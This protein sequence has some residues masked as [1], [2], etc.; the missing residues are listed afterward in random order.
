[1]PAFY[2][3]DPVCDIL[4]FGDSAIRNRDKQYR[5]GPIDF[6]PGIWSND[7]RFLKFKDWLSVDLT[8]R[9][10]AMVD[11]HG[12][13]FGN[14]VRSNWYGLRYVGG[15]PSTPATYPLVDNEYL[16][17][18]KGLSNRIVKP[19]HENVIR[20]ITRLFF[21]DLVPQPM[22][23]RVN[24][25][26][27]MPHYT[28][29]MNEKIELATYALTSGKVAAELIMKGD[30]TTAWK[31]YYIGGAYH[32]VYRR[33]SSDAVT[34]ENGVFT[35][36]ERPVAD[37]EYALSGGRK[38]TFAPTNRYFKGDEFQMVPN[39]FR[40]RNRTAMGGPLGLNAN[41]M[42]IAQ[43][44][45]S[46]I[47]DRYAF[48]YH[49]TTRD[50]QQQ[51]MRRFVMNVAADVSNHD[52]FFPSWLIQDI[53]AD[54]L[55]KM[56]F[57]E[58][59]VELY[60]L[61]MKLPNY[62]TDVGPGEG[63]VLLGDWRNPSNKGGLPSGN[64]FTDI[65]GTMLMTWCYF[66][67]QVEHTYPEVIP[68]LQTVQSACVVMD[69]YLRGKMPICLKDKSDDA[70]LGWQERHLI[71]RAEKLLSMMKDDSNAAKISPYMIISYEHGGAFLG[72]ILL[73]PESMDPSK[74]IL[75][76][77]INSLAVNAF[78]PEYGVQGDLKKPEDRAKTKRPY[79]GL[80]WETLSQNY[81]SS[82][83]YGDVMDRIEFWWSRAFDFS[84]RQYRE[85][86]LIRDKEALLAAL[87]QRSLAL[88]DLSLIEI[89]VLSDPSKLDWKYDPSQVSPSIVKLMFN[90]LE[91]EQVVPYFESVVPR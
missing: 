41:L 63:N 74:L 21:S 28:R 42:P 12:R 16:R 43:S 1:M 85:E 68:Q 9:F 80:A 32:T 26:S 84:Y 36:K 10:P 56:G 49:H 88:P 78:S 91:L 69:G 13:V 5:E 25:S 7:Y 75:I 6:H 20:A 8:K 52:W 31:D 83:V 19:W 65:D 48:T 67:V 60:R 73:Y 46:R 61:R 72:S 38:G 17:E 30:Y 29:K 40:E 77:N 15:Y 57:A 35:P 18:K 2:P 81:G 70:V 39:M 79:S 23:L 87:K 44:V 86:W 89:E 82:P 22:R 76:G 11:D 71:P 58:W 24:S 51:D 54:E 27:M 62:V 14:G 50:S 53:V 33:Q 47:Y 59:W 66:L 64:A 90:G 55:L 37:K 4:F 45:R 34:Y 3:G